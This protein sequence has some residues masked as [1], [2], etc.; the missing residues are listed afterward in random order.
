M[1]RKS[2][3]NKLIKDH[4]KYNKKIVMTLL[5]HKVQEEVKT[6]KEKKKQFSVLH[7]IQVDNMNEDNV[8]KANK[9]RAGHIEAH[10]KRK[11]YFLDKL[12]QFKDYK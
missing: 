6:F 3:F 5:N 4:L 1:E 10:E 11:M 7:H 8:E 9:V 2:E 12:K